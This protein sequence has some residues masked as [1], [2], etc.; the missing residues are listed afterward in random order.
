MASEN[1]QHRLDFWIQNNLNVLFIGNHG[2]G[3]TAMVKEA[4]TK[5]NLKWAYYSASTMDPWVDFIG[6]PR[7]TKKIHNGE[8]IT[9]LE[10]VRP[11]LFATGEVEALFFDEFNRSHKKVRNAVME[12]LQFK[13]INGKK[14]PNLRMVWSAINPNDEE[15][16]KYDVEELDPAQQDRFEIIQFVPYKPNVEFFRNKYGK[17]LAD[18]AISWWN[19]L[20]EAQKKLV[21]PRRLDY[22]LKVYNL[23]GD[24]RDVLPRDSN[25][26]KLAQAIK[27]GSISDRLAELMEKNDSEESRHFLSNENNFAAAMRYIGEADSLMEYFL[28]LLSKEK[29][30]SQMSDN[31]KIRKHIIANCDRIP[32]FNQVCHSITTAN[33]DKKLTQEI[34]RA[35]AQNT[36]LAKNFSIATRNQGNLVEMHFNANTGNNW[37][38]K[39][40]E[41]KDNYK[42]NKQDNSSVYR[43]VESTIPQTMSADEALL[44]LEVLNLVTQPML[45]SMLLQPEMKNLPGMINH[46]VKEFNRHTNMNWSEILTKH[47]SRFKDL[48]SQI[49][50]A[51][52]QGKIVQP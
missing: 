46:C 24:M 23:K 19:E 1:M 50:N 6:V 13:S 52:L 35:F 18:P 27:T 17:Q 5:N 33:T 8:E 7:E 2:V 42:G 28:P 39:L 31:A 32:V 29:I 41:L 26:T 51:G 36:E 22:A 47:G 45:T 14:F 43:E 30:A 44:C 20:P 40:V 4:F 38:N 3:K 37:K 10:L 12:L 16:F 21:S 25:V 48:L 34:R 9:Y 49:Q 11:E 15:Q